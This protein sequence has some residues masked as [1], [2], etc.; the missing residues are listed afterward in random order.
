MRALLFGFSLLLVSACAATATEMRRA[1]E[2]YEQARFDAARVWLT[3]LED[4]APG[5]EPDMRAD[6]FYLRGMTEYRLAHRLEAMHYLAIARELVGS[7]PDSLRPEQRENLT[8][9]LAELEPTEP[10]E[11]RPRPA[12]AE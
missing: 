4:R 5:M 11:Y 8:R 6:Y 12:A 2:A 7:D 9:T 3:D 1:E 10:L